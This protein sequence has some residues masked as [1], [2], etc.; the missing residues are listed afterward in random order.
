MLFN[1]IISFYTSRILLDNL[2]LTDFGI[3]NVVD[4]VKLTVLCICVATHRRKYVL[5]STGGKQLYKNDLSWI[6]FSALERCKSNIHRLPEFHV[7]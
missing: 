5:P 6:R 7:F 4:E 3:S 1:L 2:G